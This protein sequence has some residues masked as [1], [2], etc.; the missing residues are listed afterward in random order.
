MLYIATIRMNVNKYMMEYSMSQVNKDKFIVYV[1]QAIEIVRVVTSLVLKVMYLIIFFTSNT[2]K[3]FSF[4][5]KFT[6]KNRGYFS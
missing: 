3:H 2:I 6:N 5:T 1:D 4:K